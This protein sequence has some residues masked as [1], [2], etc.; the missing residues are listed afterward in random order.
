MQIGRQLLLAMTALVLAACASTGSRVAGSA[1]A[2][3]EVVR[4]SVAL[5]EPDIELTEVNAGGAQQ[6]RADWTQTARVM[7]PEALRARLAESGVTIAPFDLPEDDAQGARYRQLVQLH[8]AVGIS[9]LR[10]GYGT[11][12][13]PSKHG[14]FDWTL[15]PGA[16]ELKHVTG[17]DYALFVTIR[18]SYSSSGR[19]AM[20]VVGAL[21]G[22]GL[23]GGVQVGFA[24]LVD[25][26]DG[27]VVWFN[28][29]VDHGGDLRD[30]EGAATTARLLLK[31][32]PL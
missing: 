14:A 32:L 28:R 2:P 29:L 9:I 15:G 17:A 6:P 20:M 4:G 7:L 22:V 18:D 26:R 5:V 19:A 13:L 16:T 12:A 31:D 1:R 10:H 11:G 30:G 25:L 23:S 27:R 24:S 21:V 3:V 8:R